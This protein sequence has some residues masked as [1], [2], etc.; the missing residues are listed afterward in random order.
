MPLEPYWSVA[1]IAIK[2]DQKPGPDRD[3]QSQVARHAALFKQ[4]YSSSS[5]G[6]MSNKSLKFLKFFKAKGK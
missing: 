1:K 4:F 6:I 2:V 5:T 3:Q